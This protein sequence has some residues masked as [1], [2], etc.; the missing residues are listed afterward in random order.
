MKY[1]DFDCFKKNVKIRMKMVL[2]DSARYCNLPNIPL[3]V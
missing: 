1:F 3:S 2:H